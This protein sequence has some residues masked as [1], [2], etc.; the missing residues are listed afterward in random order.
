MATAKQVLANR[1]NAQ[2]STGPQTPEGKAVVAQNP[3]KHGLFAQKNLI[4][5][6]DPADYDR[7]RHALLSVLRP[8]DP[9]ELLL[10]ERIVALAWRLLRTNRMQAETLDALNRTIARDGWWMVP[11]GRDPDPS[12]P[13][14]PLMLGCLTAR[15]FKNDYILE[16]LLTYEN[17]LEQTIY[18]A[19]LELQNRQAAR[20]RLPTLVHP[21]RPEYRPLQ[22]NQPLLVQKDPI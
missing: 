11:T 8:A 1:R 18:R 17:R 6:E 7:H 14:P 20:D 16:R 9:M 10:A 3:V 22:T 2:L 12:A 21:A 13:Q 19:C 5:G 4:A 15:D